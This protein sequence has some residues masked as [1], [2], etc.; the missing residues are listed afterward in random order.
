[1]A[2]KLKEWGAVPLLWPIQPDNP[3]LIQATL[4]S[5]AKEADLIVAGGGSGRGLRDYMQDNLSAAAGC[6]FPLF[7]TAPESE[8]GLLSWTARR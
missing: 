6:I 4:R 8:Q 2:A 1:M 7:I 5:A 3:E